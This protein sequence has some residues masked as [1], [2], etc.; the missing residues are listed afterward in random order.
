MTNTKS[1]KDMTEFE[2]LE[3]RH[4]WLEAG[5]PLSHPYIDAPLGPIT[6]EPKPR[7]VVQFSW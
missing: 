1:I 6:N 3:L 5:R 2:F 7:P 4:K